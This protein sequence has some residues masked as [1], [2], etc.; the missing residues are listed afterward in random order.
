MNKLA[1]IVKVTM[2]NNNTQGAKDMQAFGEACNFCGKRILV[3][4]SHK[5]RLTLAVR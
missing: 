2:K 4:C 1:P 3:D 5:E